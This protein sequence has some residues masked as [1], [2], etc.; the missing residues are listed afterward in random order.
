MYLRI[1]GCL[2]YLNGVV[3]FGSVCVYRHV[4]GGAFEVP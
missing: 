2:V 3:I 1:S 4:I